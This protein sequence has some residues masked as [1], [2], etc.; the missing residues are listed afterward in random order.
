MSGKPRQLNVA[1][2]A[3]PEVSASTL[4][5][6]LDI[7]CSAGRD[8]SFITKGVP[9]VQ[10]I[11]PLVVARRSDPFRASNGVL[12]QP[13]CSLEECMT[14]D[15]VCIPDF[16]V[17]PGDPVVHGFDEEVAWLRRCHENGAVMSS[18][19]SG[20]V[21]LAEAGLLDGL[22]ATIHWSYANALAASYPKVKVNP[23]RALV[24]DGE[25]HRIILAGGGLSWQ[26][27]A[28][29]LIARF[30][31]IEEAIEVARVY[32][33][34]WHDVGQLPYASLMMSRP[35]EDGVIGKC[36]A[37]LA[38]NYSSRSP[39]A[40]MTAMS[41]LS[42]RGFAR[43]FRTATGYKP[44]D[45]VHALRLEEAKQVLERTILGIDEV[46]EAVGYEEVSFF[47]RLFN[48]K[49]GMSPAAYRRRFGGLRKAIAVPSPQ[50]KT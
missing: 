30:V 49:V 20:A 24:A 38:D 25:G 27:L 28:L 2:L 39:V 10:R 19:C 34:A 8:F 31:G 29:Y 42:E 40:R 9:G 45:Y 37:W 14:P 36:Q 32:I 44:L 41:G 43:R 4:Y 21:L 6:M 35:A 12:I 3:M 15:I 7:L 48:R 17:V 33:V 11:L 50:S 18:A 13:D 47:R 16:F 5:G 26:D 1:L 23:A 22:E 46:S